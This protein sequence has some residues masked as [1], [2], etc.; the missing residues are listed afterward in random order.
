[1]AMRCSTEQRRII[2]C[3]VE[4]EMGVNGN[5]DD[6]RMVLVLRGTYYQSHSKAR[7]ARMRSVSVPWPQKWTSMVRI[8]C[9]AT[10]ESGASLFF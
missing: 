6:G 8:N 7:V 5:G 10:C 4:S 2:N 3:Y 9:W 1:M